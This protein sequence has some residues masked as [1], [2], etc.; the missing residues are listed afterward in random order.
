MSYKEK[1]PE[2]DIFIKYVGRYMENG[3]MSKLSENLISKEDNK[4]IYRR[5]QNFLPT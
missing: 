3:K 4:I 2:K 1:N 5:N